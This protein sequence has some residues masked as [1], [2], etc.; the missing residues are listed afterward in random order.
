MAVRAVRR[1][2]SFSDLKA[3]KG[4]GLRVEVVSYRG[5]LSRDLGN[6]SS[7][8]VFYLDDHRAELELSQP[9]VEAEDLLPVDGAG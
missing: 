9:D 4:F 2:L 1:N 3:V 6:E 7:A 8:P 5:S